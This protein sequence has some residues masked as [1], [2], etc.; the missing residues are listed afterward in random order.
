M[1]LHNPFSDHFYQHNTIAKRIKYSFPITKRLRTAILFYWAE[2][3]PEENKLTG[4]RNSIQY[5]GRTPEC[6]LGKSVLETS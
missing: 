6:S 2:H 3:G 1:S 4:N 5:G